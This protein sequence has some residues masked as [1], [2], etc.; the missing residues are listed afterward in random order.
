MRD[1][2]EKISFLKNNEIFAEATIRNGVKYHYAYP[3]TPASEVLRYTAR[4]MTAA[5]GRVFQPESEVAVINALAGCAMAGGFGMT[6]TSGPG[7]SLMQETISYMAAAELPCLILNDMRVGPGDGDIIGAQSDY[8]SATRGG[9]H[10]DYRT[11]VLAP[12]S[13]Q[14][15][16]DLMPYAIASACRFRTPVIYL[17]DGILAQMTES[18]SFQPPEDIPGQFPTEWA[19]LGASGRPKKVMRSGVYSRQEGEDL[20]LGLDRKYKKISRTEQR[21]K[22][23]F[24]EDAQVVISAFGLVGRIAEEAVEEL[25]A[26]GLKVGLIRP[27]SLWPFPFKAFEAL[28]SSVRRILVVEMNMGQMVEDVHIAVGQRVGI[29]F[30]GKAGGNEPVPSVTH[31]KEGCRSLLRGVK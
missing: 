26:E 19:V 7:W 13:A 8:L 4:H 22:S 18:V 9:G 23:F 29:D 27:I 24:M 21:W 28:P 25:Q 1:E 12:A 11:I 17:L 2:Q 16:V 14:E 5:G 3:I 20:V 10:G 31:I 30:M 6:S 15:I